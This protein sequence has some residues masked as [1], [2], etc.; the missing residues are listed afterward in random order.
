MDILSSEMTKYAANAML[1][2]TRIS[3]MN[4]I[5]EICKRV[6][7]SVNEVRKGIGS[8]SRI[9]YSFLYPGAGYG[10]SCLPKDIRALISKAKEVSLEPL[11]LEAV[12]RVNDRQKKLL[13]Q[14]HASLFWEPRRHK[15][16]NH[17]HLG[18]LL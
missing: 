15:K 11:L 5:A 1:K 13:G 10:G 4:E 17:R 6:G 9:G 8:D 2:A 14:R 16:Q 7:A 18:A 12:D 3:F